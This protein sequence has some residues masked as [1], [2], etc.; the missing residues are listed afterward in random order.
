MITDETLA[1]WAEQ[2]RIDMIADGFEPE[3]PTEAD[4]DYFDQTA[5][6]NPDP[7]LDWTPEQEAGWVMDDRIE[8]FRNEY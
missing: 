6:E 1:A 2:D 4:L 8:M 5:F 7:T 3:L